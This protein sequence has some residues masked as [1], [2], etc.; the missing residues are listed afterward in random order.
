MLFSF[1]YP[2]RG[3]IYL[4]FPTMTSHYNLHTEWE[5]LSNYPT[6]IQIFTYEYVL[7]ENIAGSILMKICGKQLSQKIVMD[8][9][10]NRWGG[11]GTMFYI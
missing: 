2:S 8:L 9:L 3:Q 10:C 6:E 11:R 5:L 4:T 1:K 7:F